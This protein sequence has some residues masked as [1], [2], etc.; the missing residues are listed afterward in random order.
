MVAGHRGIAG[1]GNR[2]DTV[3]WRG[4]PWA[5]PLMVPARRPSSAQLSRATSTGALRTSAGFAFRYGDQNRCLQG[6]GESQGAAGSRQ[7]TH[8][9][10]CPPRG[11]KGPS[12]GSVGHTAG[13]GHRTSACFTAPAA[14]SRCMRAA[15]SSSCRPA[16]EQAGETLEVL[17]RQGQG[18][19]GLG[20]PPSAWCMPS[21]MS[22]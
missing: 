13:T 8:F 16:L 14:W 22:F 3:W 15:S 10:Q 11:R 19:I 2:T 4:P 18:S 1:H 21:F 5:P 6:C 12:P 9:H 7:V 17:L 20:R